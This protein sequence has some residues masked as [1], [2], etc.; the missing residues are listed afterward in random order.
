M[1]DP[2]IPGTPTTPSVASLLRQLNVPAKT[3]QQDTITDQSRS[4]S[5]SLR[6]FLEAAASR[7]A[8][9]PAAGSAPTG[10]SRATAPVETPKVSTQDTVEI[11][12][13]ARAQQLRQQGM[14]FA[15]IAL[16]MGLDV[17]TV[18]SYFPLSQ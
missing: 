11:S 2:T 4:S 13:P 10:P 14:S 18:Q 7:P 9:T 6:S 15:D 3:P 16:R 5:S 17:A 12:R 8:P 1:I